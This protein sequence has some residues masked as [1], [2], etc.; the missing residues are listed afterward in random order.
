MRSFTENAKRV[1][2]EL[3]KISLF[4]LYDKDGAM[5]PKVSWGYSIEWLGEHAI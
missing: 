4:L 5:V 3:K 1:W 2:Q